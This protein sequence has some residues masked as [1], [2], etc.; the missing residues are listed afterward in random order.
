MERA[1]ERGE[2]P[3]TAD[4]D[5]V[6]QVIPSVAAYRT[7]IRRKPFDGGFLTTWIDGVVLPAMHHGVISS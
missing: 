3:D 6:S 5:T 7:L 4:I 2:I 1:V